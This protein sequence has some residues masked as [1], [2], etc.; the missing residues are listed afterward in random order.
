MYSGY[1]RQSSAPGPEISPLRNFTCP[2]QLS[3]PASWREKVSV[4]ENN[5]AKGERKTRIL[6]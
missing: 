4:C 2:R 5:D 3:L 1:N 6:I